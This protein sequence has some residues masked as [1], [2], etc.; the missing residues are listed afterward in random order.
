MGTIVCQTCLSII[1]TFEGKK[2]C[3]LYSNCGCKK[4][5]GTQNHSSK[6]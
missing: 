3:V 5:K 4:N 6:K 2:V 1:D